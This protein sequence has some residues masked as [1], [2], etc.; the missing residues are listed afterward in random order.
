MDFGSN[1]GRS[2]TA[3]LYT[4]ALTATPLPTLT[5]S[6]VFSGNRQWS[7][8]TTTTSDSIV[9]YNAAQ[10]YRGL[11]ATLNLGATFSSEEG[12]GG[13]SRR[14]E[15]YVNLGTGIT[16]H[17]ALTFA[18]YYFGKIS[19][20]SGRSIDAFATTGARTSGED[21]EQRL[22][23]SA[24]F[25]PFRTLTLSAAASI[26]AQPEQDTKVSQNYGLAWAPFPDGTL[27]FTFAYSESRQPEDVVSR[28]IQPTVRWYLTSRRRSYLEATYQLATTTAPV[29]RSESQL[30]TTTLNIYY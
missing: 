3:A 16:P 17:P 15:M 9:F 4:A 29:L 11:D 13:D 25:T 26:D 18:S 27:Q 12:P 21:V 20:T 14:Q 5:D 24:S 30:F 10:L 7:G 22:D 1:Q 19:E 6:L 23:L 8:D 2:T 28:I